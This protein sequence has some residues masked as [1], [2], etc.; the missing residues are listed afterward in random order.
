MVNTITLLPGTLTA[1]LNDDRLVVHM[2]D[3]RTDLAR[4]MGAVEARVRAL[5][6][7][8]DPAAAGTPHPTPE[9]SS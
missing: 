6:A 4:E 1:E 5:F 3:T 8:P 2:L 7:L 9:P